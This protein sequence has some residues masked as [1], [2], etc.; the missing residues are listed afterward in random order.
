[1]YR[2]QRERKFFVCRHF[3]DLIVKLDKINK[4]G[5]RVPG[6]WLGG[7]E[8]KIMPTHPS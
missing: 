1:M 8:V 6:G 2:N 4:L 5:Q 3:W 7:N